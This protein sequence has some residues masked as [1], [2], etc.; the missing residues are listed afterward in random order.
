L[1]RPVWKL[2]Q[3]LAMGYVTAAAATADYGA[4]FTTMGGVDEVATE[5]HRAQLKSK[6]A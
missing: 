3:D 4:V 2:Q 6:A 5:Q 1:E